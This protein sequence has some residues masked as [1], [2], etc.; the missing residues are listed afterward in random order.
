M[1]LG[2]AKVFEPEKP[3]DYLDCRDSTYAVS[4]LLDYPI[5]SPKAR[6]TIANDIADKSEWLELKPNI[7][8][9]GIN[10]NAI[11]RDAIEA[12]QRKIRETDRAS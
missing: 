5:I 12:F 4:H 8:G 2:K 7:A 10:L 3:L 9:I 6:K 1:L 11:I